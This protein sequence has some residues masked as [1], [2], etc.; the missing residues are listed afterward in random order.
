MPQPIV[1]KERILIDDFIKKF[2]RNVEAG[3][4]IEE[5][6]IYTVL[7]VLAMVLQSQ[8]ENSISGLD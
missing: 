3:A 1:E 2:F 5:P 7:L 6:C 4:V 8:S